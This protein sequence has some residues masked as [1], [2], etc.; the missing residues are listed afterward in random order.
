MNLGMKVVAE[1][2]KL[3][4]TE[5]DKSRRPSSEGWLHEE[6]VEGVHLKIAIADFDKFGFLVRQITA[7]RAGSLPAGIAIKSLLAEQAAAIGKRVTYLLESFH[8]VELDELAQRAQVRSVTPYREDKTIHYYE[9]M[10]EQGSALT[11]SRYAANGG[12][13]GRVLEAFHVTDDT[14]RRLL[15]DLAAALL[16]K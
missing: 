13:S 14:C 1:L 11:F 6:I 16:I 10:L 2:D 8:L 9:A 5:Y 7:V 12:Q 3:R 4:H 15:N